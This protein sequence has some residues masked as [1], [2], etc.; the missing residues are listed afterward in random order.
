MNNTFVN[1][2]FASDN[3]ANR[4][5][6]E[7]CQTLTQEQFERPLGLGH[8]SIES[9]LAHLIGGMIF[10]ADRLNRTPRRPRPDRDDIRRSPA[11]LR[12]IFN[13]AEADLQKAIAKTATAH[14]MT[15][16]L[17]WTDTDTSDID[18]HDKVA[19]AVVFAQMIDHSIHHRTQIMDML[20]LLGINK[21]MDW[22]PFEW[23]EATHAQ[24]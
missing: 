17:N 19:Y 8:G 15:D 10:F 24:G 13:M 11:E 23:D 5:L 20:N 6:L 2:L 21:P 22:H 18:P 9:T 12:D 1:V 16:L 14:S 7:E 4:L 3:W